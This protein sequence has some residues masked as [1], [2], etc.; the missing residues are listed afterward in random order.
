[1]EPSTINRELGSANFRDVYY[2]MDQDY[3]DR[4]EEGFIQDQLATPLG[5][6]A[7]TEATSKL[8]EFLKQ[9]LSISN[10]KAKWLVY[11][12]LHK[13]IGE[14]QTEL[15]QVEHKMLPFTSADGEPLS[16]DFAVFDDW[17]NGHLKSRYLKGVGSDTWINFI[18]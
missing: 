8:N 5:A 10:P 13:V 7:Y 4:G 12:K 2:D 11:T 18:V 16:F 15:T 3:V 1:M 14:M 6:A 17:L 9:S